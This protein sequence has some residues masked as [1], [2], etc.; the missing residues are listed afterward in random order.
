MSG[1]IGLLTVKGWNDFTD[2]FFS[3]PEYFQDL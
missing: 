3:V 1:D 2:T